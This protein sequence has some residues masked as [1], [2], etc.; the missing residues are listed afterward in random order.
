MTSCKDDIPAK[1]YAESVHSDKAFT[2][3]PISPLLEKLK[4]TSRVY[5]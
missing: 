1:A 2:F 4:F 5:E 3:I